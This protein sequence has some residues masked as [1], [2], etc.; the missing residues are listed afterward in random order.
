MQNAVV[1]LV[2]KLMIRNFIID[3]THMLKNKIINN[4][5]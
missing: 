3:T 1:M 5:N 4:V 2:Q